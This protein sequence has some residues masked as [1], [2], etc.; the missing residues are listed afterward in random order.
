VGARDGLAF[1]YFVFVYRI[2]CGKLRLEQGME[3]EKSGAACWRTEYSGCEFWVTRVQTSS[4][5]VLGSALPH[6]KYFTG[7]LQRELFRRRIAM[8]LS[9]NSSVVFFCGFE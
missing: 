5:A 9:A 7:C 2:F 3:S 6:M 8:L 1:G 4:A